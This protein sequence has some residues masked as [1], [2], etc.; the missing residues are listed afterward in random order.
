MKTR[1]A[2][3]LD[4]LERAS[5]HTEYVHTLEGKAPGK[6]CVLFMGTHGNEPVGLYAY[7]QLVEFFARNPLERGTLHF[8][9]S[10]PQA[11]LAYAQATTPEQERRA[12]FVDLNMNR[13]PK[14]I[15]QDAYELRRLRTLLP[16][17]QRADVAIDL[18][19]TSLPSDPMLVPIGQATETMTPQIPVA[20]ILSGVSQ[21][22]GEQFLLHHAGGFPGN[23][24]SFLL[25]CGEHEDPRSV[26][27]AV[28]S[29][30]NILHAAGLHTFPRTRIPAQHRYHV[31]TSIFFPHASYRLVRDFGNFEPIAKGDLLATG[32][33]DPIYAP[34]D[35][36]TLFAFAGGKPP[37]IAEEAIFL[38]KP[39]ISESR[40]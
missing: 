17:L 31:S 16:L 2:Q 10:N 1:L 9:V 18:H 40:R 23:A 24:A 13:L 35:G 27:C 30:Q 20:T 5:T 6:T 32:D 36:H 7:E 37:S 15:T 8:V 11:L 14:D 33:G 38:T 3:L 28:S 25:E 39:R 29:V 26:Q 34:M 12:R 22:I 19:S 21:V 4:R